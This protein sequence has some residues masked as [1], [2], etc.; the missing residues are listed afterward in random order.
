MIVERCCLDCKWMEK[1][2]KPDCFNNRVELLS[3]GFDIE[4]SSIKLPASGKRIYR[5]VSEE[6]RNKS[7]FVI[8]KNT[9]FINCDTW[10]AKNG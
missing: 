8:Y 5:K 4:L 10:E 1:T 9:P 6:A 7:N 2:Y 3:C